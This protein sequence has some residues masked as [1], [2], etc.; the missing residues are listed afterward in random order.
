MKTLVTIALLCF[1]GMCRAQG[2]AQVFGPLGE[3]VEA[4][5]ADDSGRLFI[6]TDTAAFSSVDNGAIWEWDTSGLD[7][8]D[9]A[10]F[11]E[12]RNGTL[13][14]GAEVS[15]IFRSSDYGLH[16]EASR[17][18][19]PDSSSVHSIVCDSDQ[20][21]FAALSEHGVY[22]S[23]DEGNQWSSRSYNLQND[24]IFSLTLAPDGDLYAGL[25]GFIAKSTDRGLDWA[26][27]DTLQPSDEVLALSAD[28][29]GNIFAGIYHDTIGMILR[30]RN[31]GATWDTASPVQPLPAVRCFATARGLLFAGTYGSGVWR[32]SDLGD[33]WIQMND[34]L[35]GNN[36]KVL[37][38]TIAG[39]SELFIGTLSASVFRADIA[40]AS[41][42]QLPI[43]PNSEVSFSAEQSASG[44]ILHFM[45]P[46]A[47]Q[48]ELSVYDVA[49]RR[50]GELCNGLFAAGEHAVSFD[51]RQVTNGVCFAV[52]TT[53]SGRYVR[54]FL[55]AP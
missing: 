25:T 45:L 34:T 12:M 30:S 54:P 24:L 3:D 13:L 39:D 33:H 38:S 23:S 11:V 50:L 52:L 15:G 29:A 35:T 10:A 32:S 14:A 19:L 16:W 5:L 8:P 46:A 36:L 42:V 31:N 53:L 18:G 22:Y 41:F 7:A 37:C 4:I 51:S 28:S 48:V 20:E 6:G 2:W 47:Q 49:G 26:V 17:A 9:E 43:V 44:V 40:S 27:C 1:S 21:L 55:S